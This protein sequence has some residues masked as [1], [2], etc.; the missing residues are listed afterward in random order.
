MM[1]V[2]IV[3]LRVGSADAA[4]RGDPGVND[5][6][7]ISEVVMVKLSGPC[8]THH[9]EATLPRGR[10]LLLPFSCSR[11]DM[12]G[13]P[14]IR[15]S[16]DSGDTSGAPFHL[17][18][19]SANQLTPRTLAASSEKDSC[20]L[21][22]AL[23]IALAGVSERKG[24]CHTHL[25]FERS[26][27]H[28]YAVAPAP[29]ETTGGGG[30]SGG[31]GSGER[32]AL[33]VAEGNGAALVLA[34]NPSAHTG[35]RVRLLC[36]D[37]SGACNSKIWYSL[38][39]LRQA[40]VAVA[41]GSEDVSSYIFDGGFGFVLEQVE[42]ELMCAEAATGDAALPRTPIC[43]AM[44]LADSLAE[45]GSP[46][47]PTNAPAKS[48]AL[49]SKPPTWPASTREV[50]VL[51]GA[52]D[53]MLD[54]V[55]AQGSHRPS[56]GEGGGGGGDAVY[57][58]SSRAGGSGGG[59]GGGVGP[60]AQRI[61]LVSSDDECSGPID[62]PQEG[63]SKAPGPPP[64]RSVRC[65]V[66]NETVPG[67]DAALNAH[68]DL[69]LNRDA[70]KVVVDEDAAMDASGA[71]ASAAA[72][73]GAAAAGA[74][75]GSLDAD[76]AHKLQQ[77]EY[78]TM[79]RRSDETMQR[80]PVCFEAVPRGEGVVLRC[81]HMSCEACL[82]TWV[83]GQH[84]QCKERMTCVMPR[85][86]A[87]LSEAE[88]GAL[89]GMKANAER[90]RLLLTT[91]ARAEGSNLYSCAAAGC[92]F[93]TEWLPPRRNEEVGSRLDPRS[94]A[95]A[96]A[97]SPCLK[98]PLCSLE[99]CLLCGATPYHAGVSCTAHAK[100][101]M[102][103]QADQATQSAL[104]ADATT[105]QCKGCGVYVTKVE[106]CDKFQCLCGYRFCWVCGAK[107]AKCRCTGREHVH[108]RVS[109]SRPLG[110]EWQATPTIEA[111]A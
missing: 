109:I 96:P 56:S 50:I 2:S 59:D 69:C 27:R 89:L 95:W 86:G 55:T 101:A 106:G 85:C 21:R 51:D 40:I 75:T 7:M 38:P 14:G 102:P 43:A 1:D 107:D 26:I 28:A 62:P 88:Q 46:A 34:A 74:A 10:Y 60:H 20:L 105:Q 39:P 57:S 87:V 47:W 92:L 63:P 44:P 81:G 91:A 110:F 67:D 9:S 73:A 78:S 19:Y 77:E 68:V 82:R 71:A 17:R 70:L 84:A 5:E 25:G 23:H 48:S 65:P 54:A 15:G 79:L 6:V 30:L 94:I 41:C 18:L 83:Q 53:V 61:S 36:H 76:L 108:C 99:S 16:G 45:S 72:I 32:L 13:R 90:E 29:S 66:C 37:S 42:V 111:L 97:E 64:V 31:G 35:A 103:S 4:D 8:K 3:L 12:S 80:C 49:T 98:C 52:E 22:R 58:G 100:Q 11:L 33:V 24:A 93:L 104:E